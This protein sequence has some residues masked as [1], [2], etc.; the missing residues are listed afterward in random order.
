MVEERGGVR[1]RGVWYDKGEEW[2]RGEKR[3]RGSPHLI[4]IG[5]RQGSFRLQ[6][7]CSRTLDHHMAS[8]LY[9]ASL[10]PPLDA[11]D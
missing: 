2:E 3:D 8:F 1:D 7:I 4:G 9:I 6:G 11:Q 10:W 5:A